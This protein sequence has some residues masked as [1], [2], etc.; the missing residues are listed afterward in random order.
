MA[1]RAEN[2]AS[3]KLR[4][5]AWIG[6]GLL[7]ALALCIVGTGVATYT[8]EL[9]QRPRFYCRG[10]KPELI[11][12]KPTG[13]ARCESGAF[14]SEN[15]IE[16]PSLLP[17]ARHFDSHHD[18]RAQSLIDSGISSWLPKAKW[19][20]MARLE[21]KCKSDHDCRAKPHGRCEESHPDG[22]NVCLY[23]CVKDAECAADEICVCSDPVGYCV[24]ASCRSDSDCP[25]S[26]C[27]EYGSACRGEG[28]AC[29]KQEDECSGS[30][31]SKGCACVYDDERQVRVCECSTCSI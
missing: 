28:F 21:D 6:R 30:A 9:M 15:A 29:L 1:A 12:G 25:H 14:V 2:A 31:D 22:G 19:P 20:R 7:L 27:A 18:K 3:G 13:F 17:R 24:Q 10:A 11:P 26:S 16:C 23:G 5:I 8:W 4:W